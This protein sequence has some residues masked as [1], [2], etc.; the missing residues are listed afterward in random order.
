MSAP[1]A[2]STGPHVPTSTILERLIEQAPAGDVT[3]AWLMNQLRPRSF[4]LILLLLGVCGM[5]PL[6]SPI[7]GVLLA[8]PAFQMIRADPRPIFPRRLSQRV[9]PATK[10]AALLAR[11]VPAL[12]WLERF[13]RP[14]WPT[15]FQATKRVI[16]VV[17]LLLGLGLFVP[18]P[19][20]N[21]PVALTIILIAFAYLEE[22]GILLA[23]SLAIAL[24]LFGAG[25]VA[26]W[27]AIEAGNWLAA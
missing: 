1:T 13:V 2:A 20:S 6:L 5:L 25:G 26:L 12:R 3:I 21:V 7:A 4:G 10:L 18:I 23:L 19:L 16:G 11:V 8:V 27:G 14:R 24:V 22:D 9:V 15:P 17:V